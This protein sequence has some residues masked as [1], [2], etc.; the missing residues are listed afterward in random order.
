[1]LSETGLPFR[2][3]KR[4]FDRTFVFGVPVAEAPALLDRLALTPDRAGAIL[5]RVPAHVRVHRPEGRWSIQEHAGHLLDLEAL[6]DQRLD[7]FDGGAPVLHPAD[8]ANRGPTRR[9]NDRVPGDLIVAF[10]T[11]RM[12]ILARLA[13]MSPQDL[14]RGCAPS[15]ARPADVG[16]RSLLLRCGTRRSP[17]GSHDRDRRPHRG[18]ARMRGEALADV[19]GAHSLA[20]DAE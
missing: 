8:L 12:A 7:D 15:T 4:W 5:A 20:A 19:D 11:A 9:G 18:V 13:K 1:M 3:V 17:P 16:G 14:A 2:C 10:R 6:W